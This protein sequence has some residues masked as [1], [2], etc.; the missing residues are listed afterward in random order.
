MKIIIK[1]DYKKKEKREDTDKERLQDPSNNEEKNIVNKWWVPFNCGRTGTLISSSGRN[2][3]GCGSRACMNC[4]RKKLRKSVSSLMEM[5]RYK[6]TSM[7]SLVFTPKERIK[8]SECVDKFLNDF[9]G[10]LRKWQRTHDLKFG[11]FVAECVIKEEEEH[12]NIPCPIRQYNS[13]FLN[14]EHLNNIHETC[15]NGGNCPICKGSGY[16]PSVHLHIHFV[17]CCPSFYFGD[18][19]TP[20]HLKDRNFYDFNGKGFYGFCKEN[21][22]TGNIMCELLR[23][24]KDMGK[25]ITKAC[26]VY[27]SKI[28]KTGEKVNWSET[29]RSVM[30]SSYI[31]GRR[32]HRGAIGDAYGITTTRKDY[33]NFVQFKYEPPPQIEKNCTD[34]F[35]GYV[36]DKKEQ[37]KYEG[38][39]I[40]VMTMGKKAQ[41]TH[42]L[43]EDDN[44]VL[45]LTELDMNNLK[46][47]KV[48]IYQND[49]IREGPT[50][51]ILT[52]KKEWSYAQIIHKFERWFFITNNDLVFGIGS[53]MLSVPVEWFYSLFSTDGFD[54]LHWIMEY[55]LQNDYEKWINLLH[56]PY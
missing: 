37:K 29:Q 40:D 27:L 9:R 36:P 22:M 6:K 31:Y 55:I 28:S 51:K 49:G 54:Y 52:L 41:K 2:G 18:G 11:Y 42:N 53:T 50:Q 24:R 8:N 33:T 26:L 10:L 7:Y 20:E 23:S 21:G 16:L 38:P 1:D 3:M 34:F 56:C 32:K 12:T 25:Y 4:H 17:V 5:K 48:Y 19:E 44:N 43:V 45:M 13:P 35:N 14:D 47:N 30:I 39:L 15:V 46:K